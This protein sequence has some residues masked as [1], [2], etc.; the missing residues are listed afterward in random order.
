MKV[1]DLLNSAKD[2][3]AAFVRTI[4]LGVMAGLSVAALLSPLVPLLVG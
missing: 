3:V 4:E 1:L 2:P